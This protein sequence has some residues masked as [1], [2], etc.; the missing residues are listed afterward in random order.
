MSAMEATVDPLSPGSRLDADHPEN[1][2][3]IPC[4]F[5]DDLLAD[6]RVGVDRLFLDQPI[7]FRVAEAGI[8]TQRA[9][10]II[11]NVLRIRIVDGA[12]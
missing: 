7:H 3:L 9:A 4:R 6:F 2:V 8:V 12:A 10:D 11:L 1:G 5:T